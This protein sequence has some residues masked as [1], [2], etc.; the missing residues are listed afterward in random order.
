MMAGLNCWLD[1][2]LHLPL[3]ANAPAAGAATLER[4]AHLHE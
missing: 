4:W 3:K 1:S 2:M